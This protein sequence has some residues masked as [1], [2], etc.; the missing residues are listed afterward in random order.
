MS[1]YGFEAAAGRLQSTTGRRLSA[2]IGAVFMAQTSYPASTN[3]YRRHGL[4]PAVSAQCWLQSFSSGLSTRPA[5]VTCAEGTGRGVYG[6]VYGK[7]SGGVTGARRRV[8]L[9]KC[10]TI[11]APEVALRVLWLWYAMPEAV[12]TG[13]PFATHGFVH[14]QSAQ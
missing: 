13:R 7:W 9:G 2:V 4:S 8:S 1:R 5:A 11:P 12:I 14:R 6:M 3:T 10:K